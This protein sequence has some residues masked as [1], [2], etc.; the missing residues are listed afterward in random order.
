VAEKAV[1]LEE[2]K[3]AYPDVFQAIQEEG[4]ECWTTEEVTKE[5]DI[6]GFMAPF[7][8]A[9]RMETGKKGVLAF[10]HRPRIYYGWREA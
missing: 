4:G 9:V 8:T 1:L 2:L 10:V 6:L 7:C 3:E 5:F